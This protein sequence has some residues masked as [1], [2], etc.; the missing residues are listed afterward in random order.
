M[1][2]VQ[3]F[4]TQALHDDEGVVGIIANEG[5]TPNIFEYPC[6]EELGDNPGKP[7][8][9][10]HNTGTTQASS[11]KDD[12]FDP[13]HDS[14]TIEITAVTASKAEAKNV[15]IYVRECI[16]NAMDAMTMADKFILCDS[17]YSDR[18]VQYDVESGNYFVVLAY[19]I[20]TSI[21]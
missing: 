10:V 21:N 1:I 7:Y 5:G 17:N 4:F 3:E 16:A 8:L 11:T 18:G 20:E 12:S 19:L 6:E 9:V 14:T 2:D 13:W 15:A